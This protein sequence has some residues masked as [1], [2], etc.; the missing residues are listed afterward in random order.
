V[1]SYKL[2]T[3]AAL[4]YAATTWDVKSALEA[5]SL[6]AN[7]DVDRVV[8]GNGYRWTVSFRRFAVVNG[9]PVAPLLMDA[10]TVCVFCVF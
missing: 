6:V 2:Q 5:L 10:N 9:A 7:V 4:S 1:F 8:L 3:T